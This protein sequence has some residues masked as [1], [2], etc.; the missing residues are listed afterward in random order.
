MTLML[1]GDEQLDVMGANANM[2]P[3]AVAGEQL[4]DLQ[5]LI[6]EHGQDI[7]EALGEDL[8]PAVT[9]TEHCTVC[10][11]DRGSPGDGLL[12]DAKGSCRQI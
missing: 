12:Y 7:K 11:P 9:L 1:S 4:K 5:P 6:D 10:R 3:S 2:I 8:L